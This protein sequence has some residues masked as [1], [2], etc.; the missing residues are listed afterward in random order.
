[1][2]NFKI[3]RLPQKHIVD[4][5][6]ETVKPL[7]IKNDGKGLDFF[8][9]EINP[10]HTLPKSYIAFPIGA[11]KNTK[12][13][14][15][16]KIVKIC[17]S[18]SYTIILLGGKQEKNKAKSILTHLKEEPSKRQIVNMVGKCS[19]SDSAQIVKNAKVVI[20][21]DTGLMHIAAAFNK[22]II[23]IWG[24]TMPQFGMTP[25]YA[26]NKDFN[27]IIEVK[28]LPCRPCSKIGYDTCPK[29]HFKCIENIE[30]ATIIHQ[31]NAVFRG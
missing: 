23:S 8:M 11:G 25:Y 28:N 7:G 1:M 30:I 24:N 15:V 20:T 16:E 19:L 4:R 17:L 22:P 10:R 21:A 3:N 14:T 13:F 31:I 18:T 26:E 29:G 27:T 6:L 2:T 12:A 9:E 5:Y